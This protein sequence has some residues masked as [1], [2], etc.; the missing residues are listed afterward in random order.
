MTKIETKRSKNTSSTTNENKDT[1]YFLSYEE[2]E[3]DDNSIELEP[4]IDNLLLSTPSWAICCICSE[5][6][7][8]PRITPNCAHTF[9]LKC[10]EAVLKSVSP[11]CPLCRTP[12]PTIDVLLPNHQ[13]MEVMDT[14]LTRCSWG[15]KYDPKKEVWY[16]AEDGC[17]QI[18]SLAEFEAHVSK[19]CDYAYV[20]C[21]NEGCK[22]KVRKKEIN[23]H[24]AKCKYRIVS[25]KYCR[26]QMKVTELLK[27]YGDCSDIT[28]K[29]PKLCGES[30]PRKLIET[31]LKEACLMTEA[32]CPHH[33]FGCD[34]IG[35][36]LYHSTHLKKCIYETLKTFLN[37]NQKIIN[38]MQHQIETQQH[39]INKLELLVERQ[40][41]EIKYLR[42][43]SSS[44]SPSFID[45][46]RKNESEKGVLESFLEDSKGSSLFT[47]L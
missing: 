20:P 10:I 13:L 34:F 30:A 26:K 42:K 22:S 9:C 16:E 33:S 46:L 3:A 31:H 21:E 38:Q 40:A 28:V 1:D 25:C 23:T 11:L 32:P 27:H 7:K 36:K 2:E 37:N 41:E 18:L 43:N 6:F 15:V 24:K 8:S 47:S 35:K 5:V 29:C 4:T 19:K 17:K 44:I 12:L 14:L 45:G 39:K